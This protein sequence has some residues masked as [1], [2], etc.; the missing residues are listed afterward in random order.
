MT[1]IGEATVLEIAAAIPPIKKSV[2]K[3]LFGG[4]D[5]VYALATT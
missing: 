5:L 4:W 2:M 1:S 3:S